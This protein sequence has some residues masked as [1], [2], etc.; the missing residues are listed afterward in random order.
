MLYFLVLSSESIWLNVGFII[1]MLILFFLSRR[2]RKSVLFFNLYN[3][4]WHSIKYFWK[5]RSWKKNYMKQKKNCQK[6]NKKKIDSDKSLN[7][8]SKLSKVWLLTHEYEEIENIDD[9]SLL[10]IILVLNDKINQKYKMIKLENETGRSG[11]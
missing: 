6:K 9:F 5:K 4:C 10:N 1:K 3:R 8:L 7:I 2:K 11:T